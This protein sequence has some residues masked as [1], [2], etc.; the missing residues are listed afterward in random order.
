[1]G[2]A[3]VLMLVAAVAAEREAM[4]GRAGVS[5][6][7]V[8]KVLQLLENL[9]QQVQQEG[10]AEAATY[11]EFSCFCKDKQ[12]EKDALIKDKTS[13]DDSLTAD[14]QQLTAKKETLESELSDL[15]ADLDFDEG[16]LKR[17]IALREEEYT[18][19]K[20]VYDDTVEAV[21]SAKDAI[22]S[23]KASGGAGE[24]KL[25]TQ[26]P[27]KIKE[28]LQQGEDPAAY[29]FASGGILQT[30][31]NLE[32]GWVS[33]QTSLEQ[34]EDSA[35]VAYTNAKTKMEEKI[36]TEK[37]Q[38]STKTS[39]LAET[40]KSLGT[41]TTELTETKALKKDAETYLKDLTEQCSRK[42]KEWDQRSSL[43]KGELEALDKA[44]E[45]MGVVETKATDSG[46]GGRTG[47]KAVAGLTQ[48][49]DDAEEK[50]S[51]AYADVVF[52][53]TRDVQTRKVKHETNDVR[54]KIITILKSK[55]AT[56]KSPAINM[57][58]MKLAADPF[59]KVKELIQQLIERLNAEALNESNQKGWCDKELATAKHDRDYRL[60]DTKTLSASILQ[61][62]AQKNNLME[63]IVSSNM[64]L[65]TL[66]H[67]LNE[68]T[69]LR[70]EEKAEN[71]QTLTA[72]REG[73]AALENA[74]EV[75]TTFYKRSSREGEEGYRLLQAMSRQS[76]VDADMAAAGHGGIHKGAYKGNQAQA[77]GILG[78]LATINSDFERTIKQTSEEEEKSRADFAGFSK[79]TKASI[80]SNERGISQAKGDYQMTAADI[81]QSLYDLRENQVLLDNSV[82]QLEMLRPACIDT[83]M[84]WEQRKLARE[85]EIQA[86]KDCLDVFA[87]GLPSETFFLQKNF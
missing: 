23:I 49:E 32:D 38:I 54:N 57:L 39:E 16:S 59:V 2:P 80:K 61:L 12:L 74:I 52:V 50:D 7:P 73:K 31:E 56:L 70:G 34:Q 76:P 8:A 58:A 28:L 63:V 25:L 36:S 45:L 82:K 41:K 64:E 43:R 42:A 53:Q 72:A 75:L 60:Q 47:V 20:V 55:A 65:V 68:A 6:S 21:N 85:K 40:E 27:R 22:A 5:V 81:V 44:L 69:K 84:T 62:E 11:K 18:N 3:S 86:L 67:A 33:K 51:E 79:E 78:M 1:M 17:M 19:W 14:I 87:E 35:K 37:D 4:H 29:E 15:N 83:G 13:S 30:L 10:A 46:A 24:A 71:K 48:E 9:E 66:N 77:G 26:I